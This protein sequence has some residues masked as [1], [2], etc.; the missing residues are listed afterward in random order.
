L[1]P[2]KSGFTFHSNRPG[3]VREEGGA[4]IDLGKGQFQDFLAKNDGRQIYVAQLE[5]VG[6]TAGRWAP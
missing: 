1:F 5:N 6:N 4:E 3:R 2:D